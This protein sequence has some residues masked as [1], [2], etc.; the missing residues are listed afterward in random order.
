MGR[1]ARLRKERGAANPAPASGP[2]RAAR[3]LPTPIL[4]GAAVIAI[5]VLAVFAD[6]GSFPFLNVDDP[7]YVTGNAQ[8][9]RGLTLESVRWAFTG[10]AAGY[11]LPVTFLSHMAD[12]EMFGMDA[13]GH[14]MVSL[15][16]HAAASVLLFL[17]FVS[18][19]GSAGRSFLV[20]LLFAI[21]PLRVESV[22]WVAERKDVLTAFFWCA[23]MIAW[24]AWCHRP[25]RGRYLLVFVLFALGLM[26][27]PMMIT[28]PLA[29][30]LLDVWP[31][32]R[33]REKGW[34]ALAVEKVPLFALI[35]L[36][37]VA[38]FAA[39]N[40]WGAVRT[41][42]EMPLPLRLGNALLS[43]VEYLGKTFWPS[44]LS[45]FYP[46]ERPSIVSV[47]AAALLLAAITA[48]A[49]RLRRTRPYLLV[50]WLWFLGTLVPVIGILQ[51]GDQALA[52]RFTYLPHV[53]IFAALI[54]GLSEVADRLT[55]PAGVRAVAA[56][57]AILALMGISRNYA[58]TFDSSIHA[59]Q[60][61]IALAEHPTSD[62]HLS[63]ALGL[64]ESGRIAEAL[65]ENRKAAELDP[66]SFTARVGYAATLKAAG[67]LE[68]AIAELE[69]AA[70]ID[71][72][73]ADV[74]N[75]MG[76]AYEKT[77]S[78]ERALAEY[79]EALRLDPRLFEAEMSLATLLSRRGDARGAL[80]HYGRA[81]EIQPSSIE[82]RVYFGLGL[83]NGGERARAVSELQRAGEMD[84][85]AA[86]AIVTRALRLPAHPAN[87]NQLLQDLRAQP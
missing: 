7:Q 42:D 18:M 44:S 8:V 27:K 29:L 45:F 36:A 35:P 13:G 80:E 26:A 19:T 84:P 11:W 65:E 34:R 3:G 25:S 68:R 63:L 64:A 30:L 5:A 57:A 20:A 76:N 54:W 53:G 31:L 50:G 47:A 71:P 52:D 16:V 82:A 49:F 10:A 48:L 55:I 81:L 58:R 6:I 22:A 61:A 72:K 33:L 78:E 60:N 83:W 85:A 56:A 51:V 46:W 23:G 43:Y 12:V 28:F 41:L 67:D 74:H 87:L 15:A 62:M 79:R 24:A 38:T 40:R 73:I 59:W 77:G 70:R 86:N 32:G 17:A 75:N 39:Q 1:T 14:H 4:I 69:A 2:P 37:S 9:Q 21:H 66:G